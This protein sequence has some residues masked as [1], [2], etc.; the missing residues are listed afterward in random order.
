M[1]FDIV[2]KKASCDC[3]VDY[4]PEEITGT[5]TEC[6]YHG[7]GVWQCQECGLI[8]DNS[9]KVFKVKIKYT[10]DDENFTGIDPIELDP[11]LLLPANEGEYSSKE[12]F[13]QDFIEGGGWDYNGIDGHAI[14]IFELEVWWE[15]VSSHT[16][17]GIEWDIDMKII[18][19]K[20][21]N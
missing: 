12:C 3:T 19:E 16:D 10:I 14:G 15:Y 8:Y 2:T 4:Y 13:L 1:Y 18:S 21:G 6:Y 17:C 5:P 20:D 9:D 7:E 11:R